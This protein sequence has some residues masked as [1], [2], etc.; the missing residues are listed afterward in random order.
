[1]VKEL[2]IWVDDVPDAIPLLT[3]VNCVSKAIAKQTQIIH[4]GI[5]Y[6]CKAELI[7]KYNY[8]LYIHTAKELVHELDLSTFEQ[9]AKKSSAS[10]DFDCLVQDTVFKGAVK[11]PEHYTAE[12]NKRGLSDALIQL[13]IISNLQQGWSDGISGNPFPLEQVIF[14]Q[15]L[16]EELAIVPKVFPTSDSLQLEWTNKTAY[17]EVQIFENYLELYFT[18]GC[19]DEYELDLETKYKLNAAPFIIN[20]LIDHVLR[21]GEELTEK[22]IAE[23]FVY[24]TYT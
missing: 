16:L 1:M 8:H 22:D 13:E 5:T 24:C 11:M 4:T 6:F 21:R 9:L 14:T 2:H 19:D 15:Q 20:Y 18:V 23:V 7:E 10:N 17:L 3:T 12:W